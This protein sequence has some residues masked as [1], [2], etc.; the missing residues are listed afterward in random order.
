MSSHDKER[1]DL[2]DMVAISAL[3][4]ALVSQMMVAASRNERLNWQDLC[5]A[6]SVAMKGLAVQAAAELG[7]SDDEMLD[8]V[9][10]LF[11][12]ALKQAVTVARVPPA[13]GTH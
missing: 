12:L 5:Y 3:S 1:D 6:A 11:D 8:I 4:Q 2:P 10:K 9:R 7:K 13:R